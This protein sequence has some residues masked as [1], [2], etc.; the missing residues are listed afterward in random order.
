M[1]TDPLIAG[2]GLDEALTK[3]CGVQGIMVNELIRCAAVPALAVVDCFLV[4][5]FINAFAGPPLDGFAF[6]APFPVPGA[7]GQAII[8]VTAFRIYDHPGTR[9][10]ASRTTPR[11]LHPIRAKV[12]S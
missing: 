8:P 1:R 11:F 4:A 10:A 3:G 12:V 2:G 5:L 9:V 7:T 6:P